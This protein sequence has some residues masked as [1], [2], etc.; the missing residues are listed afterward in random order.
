MVLRRTF[1][2]LTYLAT[3]HSAVANT[4][5]YFDPSLVPEPLSPTCMEVKKDKGKEK[6]VEGGLPSISLGNSLDGD[7]PLI[8]FL[9]LLNRPL[10]LRSTPH[11]EQ[12][13]L[14]SIE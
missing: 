2:I 3:N 14:I 1:E 13:Y 8:L 6:I 9:K 5:F 7:I 4:L 11:L 12:V 10:F